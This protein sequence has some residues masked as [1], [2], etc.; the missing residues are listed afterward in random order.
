M[1]GD[2]QGVAVVSV[3]E[4]EFALEVGAP[5]VVGGEAGGQRRAVGPVPRA[6]QALDQTVPVQDGMDGALG[7]DPHVAV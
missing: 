7:R 6:T 3:A 1:V 5:Q 2:G 4:L